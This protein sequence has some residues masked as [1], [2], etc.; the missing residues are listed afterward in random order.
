MAQS[1]S[2]QNFFYNE[3]VKF[4]N[5]SQL[6]YI[7]GYVRS[8][9]NDRCTRAELDNRINQD[10]EDG[11]LPT[12]D[13]DIFTDANY[14]DL[15]QFLENVYDEQWEYENPA[16]ETSVTIDDD[17]NWTQDIHLQWMFTLFY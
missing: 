15:Y 9:A 1:L 5:A 13:W 8:F 16:A 17:E 7:W 12:L 6:E 2:N 10:I 3:I 14:R 11:W 4:C